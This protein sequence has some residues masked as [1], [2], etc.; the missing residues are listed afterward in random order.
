VDNDGLT[1]PL[2]QYAW[3]EIVPGQPE[4][5][6][7]S[8]I[9]ASYPFILPE[10]ISLSRD[11][12]Q[13]YVTNPGN[14]VVSLIDL[15]TAS[16]LGLI[17]V[18]QHPV[19]LA[20]NPLRDEVYCI[21]KESDTI[22]IIDSTQT[23]PA[24]AVIATLTTADAP[25]RGLVS[26][27]GKYLFVSC[28][29]TG[30]DSITVIDLDTRTEIDKSPISVGTDPQGMAIANQKLYVAN[31]GDNHVSVIDIDPASSTRWQKLAYNIQVGETPSDLAASEDRSFVYVANQGS[32]TVSVI[33][34][35]TDQVVNTLTVGDYPFR[36]ATAGN[37]LYVTN[38]S[39]DNV[40]MIN[41]DTNTVL[42]T[43]FG[44]GNYP[45]GIAVTPD[46]ETIYVVNYGSESVY[47]RTY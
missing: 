35:N 8:E 19:D 46:G 3:T 26:P 4:P 34:T 45:K 18:G 20:A 11:G 7:P 33:D 47:I 31:E 28:V 29:G 10:A 43:T 38:W 32:D 39:D 37:I 44:V 23:D 22:T 5:P 24:Q 40:S 14:K 41:M 30:A 25:V 6:A 17:V 15:E 9:L 12:K 13:A 21:N 27:D 36:M 1:S 42:T 2:S 16:V